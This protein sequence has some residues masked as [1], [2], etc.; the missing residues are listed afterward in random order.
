MKVLTTSK[1]DDFLYSRLLDLLQQIKLVQGGTA[2]DSTLRRHNKIKIYMIQKQIEKIK[3][4]ETTYFN[5]DGS[6][7]YENIKSL[8]NRPIRVY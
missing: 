5:E 8:Q 7:N 1:D 4:V 3:Y 2:L 6:L